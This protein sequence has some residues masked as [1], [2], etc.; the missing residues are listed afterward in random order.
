MPTQASAKALALAPE[1]AESARRARPR[2]LPHGAQRRSGRGARRARSR[3]I[4]SNYD[5][6]YIKGRVMFALGRHG[7]AA[8]ALPEACA[9]QPEAYDSWYLLGMA[10][11]KLGEERRARNADIEC[12][13]AAKKRVRQHPEDTR[14]WTMGAAV[15]AELGEPDRAADWVARALADRP[16]RSDHRLQRRLRVR[17]ARQAR[18]RAPLPRDR[19]SATAARS[20]AGWRTIPT[21]TRCATKRVFNS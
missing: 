14:A 13:E 16:R 12:I 3:S 19:R 8:D 15:F 9:S 11:R 2:A 6:H 4:R 18:R 7:E 10:S 5:A 20:T 17:R 21:S 1:L